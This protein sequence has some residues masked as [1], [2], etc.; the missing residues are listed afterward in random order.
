MNTA[1]AAGLGGG[2]GAR[3]A[4]MNQTT[5]GTYQQ[6]MGAG[7][8]GAGVGM[9]AEQG[10]PGM[11]L[12]TPVSSGPLSEETIKA[13][14][15][16]INDE[17]HARALYQTVVDKFGAQLPFVNILRAENVHVTSLSRLFTN[18]GLAV[19]A[20]TF[21][22]K[23]ETPATLQDAFKAAIQHETENATMYDGFLK[24]VKEVDVNRVF[25]Q[26][27]AASKVMHLTALN[28]YNK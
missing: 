9:G 26:L 14:T 4:G 2:N 8:G 12:Y 28:Y 24:T 17:Y 27:G 22:G 13:L 1:E 19:P 23:L 25:T 3:G 18:H 16:A 21:A 20:D 15:A 5:P 6:G 10:G 11:G 7:R